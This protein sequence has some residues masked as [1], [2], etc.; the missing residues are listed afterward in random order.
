MNNENETG[1]HDAKRLEGRRQALDGLLRSRFGERATQAGREAVRRLREEAAAAA[2]LQ[3]AAPP[4]R[5]RPAAKKP[6]RVQPWRSE[7]RPFWLAWL[8]A[9]GILVALTGYLLLS[10]PG[11]SLRGKRLIATDTPITQDLDGYCQLTLEPHSS[12]VINGGP[13]ARQAALEQGRVTCAIKKNVGT[14][15]VESALG[16]I[17]A[18]GTEFTVNL[19]REK[20]I[21]WG[22]QLS[23]KV[24]NGT[25]RLAPAWGTNV[26]LSD[27]KGAPQEGGVLTGIF[28]EIEEHGQRWIN[29]MSDGEEEDI[30]YFPRLVD[31]G[32]D[33]EM[34]ST[35]KHIY[36][37]NRVRLVWAFSEPRRVMAIEMITPKTNSGTVTGTIIKNDWA[38]DVK[39]KD[40]PPERYTP[41]GEDMVVKLKE[42]K[43]G[44]TV[45]L[46]W[47]LLPNECKRIERIQKTEK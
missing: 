7:K 45:T 28:T 25:V 21:A 27:Q 44:E 22:S 3:T 16:T 33:K 15:A 9:A 13:R 34:L 29:V 39:P 19:T 38:V 32:L 31:G 37:R 14:F 4:K 24:L 6:S 17:S 5:W 43:K 47:S 35:F 10:R 18:L 41:K 12:L 42:F 23:V 46:D 30:K 11:D 8:A 36:P 1:P 20:E 26:T 40:G 2:R